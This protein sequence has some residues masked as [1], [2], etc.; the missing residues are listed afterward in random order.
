MGGYDFA[1]S[2]DQTCGFCGLKRRPTSTA[3]TWSAVSEQWRWR[4][5]RRRAKEA[6]VANPR[7]W[8]CTRATSGTRCAR[9]KQNLAFVRAQLTC[10][11][12][13]WL[14]YLAS[15]TAS[16]IRVARSACAPRAAWTRARDCADRR[17]VG[18]R[19][20]A[21]AVHRR[22]L[23]IQFL[24]LAAEGDHHRTVIAGR[25]LAVNGVERMAPVVGVPADVGEHEAAG[26]HL[27]MLIRPGPV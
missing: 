11:G 7:F 19:I 21:D 23:P 13:R 18:A 22:G 6:V 16:A 3:G 24:I 25:G 26:A 12:A 14:A 15:P 4:C 2:R 20:G 27:A 10:D 8:I 1:A 17:I 9:Q 5:C